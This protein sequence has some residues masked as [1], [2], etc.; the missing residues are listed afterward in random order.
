MESFSFYRKGQIK[1]SKF[2]VSVR[3]IKEP[4]NLYYYFDNSTIGSLGVIR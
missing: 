1:D 4:F 2:L 3:G